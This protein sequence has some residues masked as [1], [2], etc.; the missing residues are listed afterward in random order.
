MEGKITR[1]QW[2]AAA[3]AMGAMPFS[4]R[5][6]AEDELTRWFMLPEGGLAGARTIRPTP[7]RLVEQGKIRAGVFEQPPQ[8]ANLLD[9]GTFRDGPKAG[10]HRKRLMEWFGYGLTLRDWYL[11]MIIIDAKLLPISAVYVVNRRDKTTF[12][13]NLAGGR[14]HTAS[15]P[16]NDR[17]WARG[18]GYDLEFVH[19]LDQGRHEI[20][21]DLHRPRRPPVRGKLVFHEDL[22]ARPSLNTT[23]PTIAPFFFYTHKACMPASG[24]LEVGKEKIG[25]DPQRDLAILDEHRN[26]AQTPALWTWGTAGGDYQGKLLAFNLGD[27]GG[28]DQE[29]WNENCLWIGDRLELLGPVQWTNDPRNPRNPWTVKEIHGRADLTFTPDN[30]KIVSVP[31]LGKYY[32]MA[33][34]YNGYLVN[35]AGEKLE[36]RNFYGCAENGAIG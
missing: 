26:Y 27:T 12:S 15:G 33:G 34:N 20:N 32:Q 30:G 9:A 23:V 18:P 11:G 17:T 35:Q 21:L 36:V 22:A 24:E 1:R 10:W 29:H 31:P 16:W 19:L 7:P 2:L 14:V 13:H 28:I 25:L 6:A 5:A 3:A 4:A 8:D